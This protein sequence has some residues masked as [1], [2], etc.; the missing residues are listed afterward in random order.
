MATTIITLT[1]GSYSYENESIKANGSLTIN[2]K[3]IQS[4]SG[5]VTDDLAVIGSFNA[6]RDMPESQGQL[7]FSISFTDPTKAS[8]LLDAVQDAVAAVQAKLNE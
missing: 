2:G 1:N 8:T 5:S 7:R 4:I 3:L 6:N